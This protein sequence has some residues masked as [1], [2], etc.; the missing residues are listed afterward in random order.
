MLNSPGPYQLPQ[1]LPDLLRVQVF[2]AT[3]EV[4]TE[5]YAVELGDLGGDAGEERVPG[6]FFEVLDFVWHSEYL[7]T[8]YLRKEVWIFG[9]CAG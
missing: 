4:Q 2:D 6:S 7:R 3:G 8:H 5:G 1:P 9:I